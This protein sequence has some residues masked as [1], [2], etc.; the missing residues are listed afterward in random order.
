[1]DTVLTYLFDSVHYSEGSVLFG[2]V[3]FTFMCMFLF[4]LAVT[5]VFQRRSDI[6][7]RAQ[8][9]FASTSGQRLS[10]EGNE[11]SKRSLRFQSMAENTAVMAKVERRQKLDWN[12]SEKTA[13]QRDLVAAGFFGANNVIWYQ[14]VRLFFLV[15]LPM[16]VSLL[17]TIAGIT[18]Q[19]ASVYAMLVAVGCVGF[20]LPGRYL[21]YR[22]NAM[23][24]QCREGFPDFLDLMVVCAE[25]G[26]S[27]RAAI[28]RISRE[29]SYSY[30]FLGANIYLMS[31]ELRAGALLPEAVDS[32]AARTGIEEITNMGALLAQ[33][34]QLGTSLT[35]AL[36]V[37]SEEMRDKRL[38]K[39][40]EK[41]HSLSVK[42]TIPMGLFIFPVMLVVIALPLISRIRN[43]FI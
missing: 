11:E 35:D 3:F 8:F 10:D 24:Q 34:E 21:V 20:L 27:P 43:A 22:Q 17:L 7:K 39:A 28:D 42:L 15:G 29:I 6:R 26:L 14:S 2:A 4:A 25:A 18:F 38:S 23:R 36:R 16:V 40:E 1:M 30:P 32:L 5:D 9:E 19:S 13:L 12:E 41:A 37:Y 31:L 33:T